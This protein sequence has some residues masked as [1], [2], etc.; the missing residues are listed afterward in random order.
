MEDPDLS[1]VLFVEP[2]L[3]WIIAL[4][5]LPSEKKSTCLM[6]GQLWYSNNNDR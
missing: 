2:G 3:G 5:V 4:H 1:K 6:S